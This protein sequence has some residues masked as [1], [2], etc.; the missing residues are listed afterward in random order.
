MQLLQSN[1]TVVGK[2]RVRS[3]S[4]DPQLRQ[5]I[6]QILHSATLAPA[7]LPPSATLVIRHLDDPLPNRF[8]AGVFSAGPDQ[9][10]QRAV[11][12]K[13]H[14]LFSGAARPLASAVPAAA[15]AIL[16][17]NHAEILA[18]LATDWL[19]GSLSTNWWWQCI[20][21]SCG[22]QQAN[23][24]SE[25][26]R[27][28][29]HVPAALQLLAG[30]NL[31]QGFA[32]KLTDDFAKQLRERVCYVHG[33]REVKP[34]ELSVGLPA[35]HEELSPADISFV[36]ESQSAMDF[37]KSASEKDRSQLIAPWAVWVPEASVPALSLE[38]Q[39]LLVQSLMLAR[40]PC[41]ARSAGFQR[42]VSTWLDEAQKRK[43]RKALR[44]TS[45][46]LLNRRSY[47]ESFPS[48][49]TGLAETSGTQKSF[50]PSEAISLNTDAADDGGP[51]APSQ[52]NSF[53]NLTEA[54]DE[55]LPQTVLDQSPASLAAA[56]S[57]LANSF[58]LASTQIQTEF[59]GIFF[60]LNVALA[61]G[62]YSDFTTPLGPNLEL[63]I[64]DF[65]A[66]L[67][68]KFAGG[69][70]KRD[71][72]WN[73][74]AALAGRAS[75][76]EPGDEFDPP[77]DWLIPSDWLTPFAPGPTGP[78]ILRNGRSQVEHPQGFLTQDLQREEGQ[79]PERAFR[80]DRWLEWVGAYIRARL[81]LALGRSDAVQFLCG[82]PARVAHTATHLDITYGLQRHP[83]E[84]RIAGLDRNPGWIPASGRY[85]SFHFE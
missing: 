73:L 84:I 34:A 46:D 27:A 78:V 59:G 82:C 55:P 15:N 41:E 35:L 30:E 39:L 42:S 40:K 26:M 17:L 20:F 33:I 13:L 36:S 54:R 51:L 76:A 4:S 2:L 63:S 61:L 80:V 43:T 68:A 48:E 9:G 10:W 65:L 79:L 7:G 23:L 53:V 16:F 22:A 60:L 29:E 77:N 49:T 52:A 74:L 14:S 18:S 72:L 1:S 28:P 31:V 58:V 64:W 70:L 83:V 56:P 81:V 62:L 57:S 12:D 32:R 37:A 44:E 25:W 50:A 66:L 71:E 75:D 47:G 5:C 21:P 67:G 69:E 38:V 8:R 11:N 6:Q 19:R 45:Q 3:S 85:I 24:L